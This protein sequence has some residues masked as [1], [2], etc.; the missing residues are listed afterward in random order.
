MRERCAQ[1]DAD[2]L[3]IK[4]LKRPIPTLMEGNENRHHLTRMQPSGSPAC[5]YRE[6]L[7]KTLPGDPSLIRKKKVVYFAEK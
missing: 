4:V 5:F 3:E 7:G 6:N 1:I 2:M